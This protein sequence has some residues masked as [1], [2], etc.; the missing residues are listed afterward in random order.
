MDTLDADEAKTSEDLLL[1]IPSDTKPGTYTI[2]ITAYY[3]NDD[4]TA[5]KEIEFDVLE[6]DVAAPSTPATPSTPTTPSTPST[7]SAPSSGVLINYDSNSK[8]LTQGEGGAIYSVTIA[9][10]GTA[11]KSF[12]IDASGV[13]WATVRMSPGNVVVVNPAVPV[14]VGNC[15]ESLVTKIFKVCEV[16]S[17]ISIIDVLAVC[18]AAPLTT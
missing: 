3:N 17:V 9:N 15:P 13:D 5:T 18:V 10:Q 11:A 16:L 4:D 6:S 14:N 7:P 12:V 1:R 8:V 2:K